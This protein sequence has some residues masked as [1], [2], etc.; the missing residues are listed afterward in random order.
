MIIVLFFFGFFFIFLKQ[1]LFYLTSLYLV[2]SAVWRP[3]CSVVFV[4]SFLW[5]TETTESGK[6]NSSKAS[7]RDVCSLANYISLIS[8]V[9]FGPS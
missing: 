6:S 1:Y 7:A 4:S 2:L 8:Q 3:Y 9:V 5:I